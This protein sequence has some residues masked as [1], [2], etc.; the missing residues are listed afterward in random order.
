MSDEIERPAPPL[1]KD[2][3][4]CGY[5]VKFIRSV[6]RVGVL[7]EAHRYRCFKCNHVVADTRE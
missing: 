4:H 7:P 2:C 3:K 5:M 6:P 1:T